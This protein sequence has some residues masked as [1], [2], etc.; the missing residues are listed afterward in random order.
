MSPPSPRKRQPEP[1]APAAE[2]VPRSFVLQ[3]LDSSINRFFSRRAAF[4]KSTDP[5]GILGF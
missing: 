3:A 1:A 5:S 2:A 4:G